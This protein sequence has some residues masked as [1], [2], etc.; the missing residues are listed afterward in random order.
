MG[1]FS[2]KKKVTVDD[3]AM[4][5]MLAAVDVIGKIECF[6][7]ISDERSMAVNMGYFYGF[8]KLH[9]NSITKLETADV[10]VRKSINHII[11]A[12]KGQNLL[13]NFGH[14]V[15]EIADKAVENMKYAAKQQ[16]K[17]FLCMAIFYMTDLHGTNTVDI[18]KAD[19]A[20]KNMRTLYG[21][22]ANLTKDIKIVK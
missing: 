2:S 7:D 14:T 10:I 3:L 4:Q 11:R 20:E 9:L 18:A 22:T 17:T 1:L 19:I 13:E 16:E 12:T 8:L 5:M 6:N 21:I 15:L